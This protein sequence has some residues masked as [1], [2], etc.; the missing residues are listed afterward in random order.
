LGA[1]M[2][3]RFR[4]NEGVFRV[5]PGC[6]ALC[7]LPLLFAGGCVARDQSI[8]YS[9]GIPVE[10]DRGGGEGDTGMGLTQL[11]QPDGGQATIFYPA[12]GRESAFQNGP[13]RLSVIP[14]GVPIQ[15]NRRLIVVSH[16]SGGSP[17]VHADLARTLVRRGFTVVLP[18]HH[19]DNYLD[20]SEPGPASWRLRPREVSEAIDIVARNAAP[21][22]RLDFQSVGVFGGSAGGHTALSLA[23]GQWSEARFRDH[24]DRHME[25]DFPS[26]VGFA[27]RLRGDGFD[28]LKLWLA[29]RVIDWR[30]SDETL[31]EDGDPRIRAAVAMVPFAA[32]FASDSLRHPKIPLGLIVAEKDVNQNPRFHVKA[33]L[34]VCQPRCQLIMNLPDA[35]HGAMLSPLP[36]LEPGGIAEHLLGDPPEFDR[37]RVIPE[38]NARIADFFERH[39][40]PGAIPK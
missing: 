12:A 24:C 26:C 21:A 30:F 27:L 16:G 15:G 31:H 37:G 17:W 29:K 18:R 1:L 38:L 32:D 22:A 23:G 35:G 13:F 40:I 20:A 39:L 6:L 19:A 14:D 25:Q 10:S 5:S 11:S 36:P 8:G 9:A 34:D 2:D 33:V 4:G 3:S 7:L 28:G